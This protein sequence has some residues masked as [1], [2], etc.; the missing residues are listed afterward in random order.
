MTG[1]Q[2]AIDRLIKAFRVPAH[3]VLPDAAYREWS[4]RH[5]WRARWD[6]IVLALGKLGYD[7]KELLPLTRGE[8]RS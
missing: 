7:L 3:L 6:H 8:P 4:A 2:A 1:E 5:P